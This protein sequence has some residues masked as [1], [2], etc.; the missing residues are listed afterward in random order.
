[1]AN[2]SPIIYLSKYFPVAEKISIA[3]FIGGYFLRLMNV[4][5]GNDIV[6]LSLSFLSGIYFLSAYVPVKTSG[7]N[8]AKQPFGF[9][10]LL[11][12]N[13]LPKVFGI[14]LSVGVTG[15]LFTLL[16]WNGFR[17]MLT[18]GFT[19]LS[20]ASF[21]AFLFTIKDEESRKAFEPRLFR[22]LLIILIQSYFL[23]LYGLHDPATIN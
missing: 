3:S 12:Q 5:A 17:E 14:G 16:Q 11:T 20:A 4:P 1:M 21:L 2:T 6:I 7:E 9:I 18:I 8:L 22:S 13:I 15:I 10:P 19:A 23:W